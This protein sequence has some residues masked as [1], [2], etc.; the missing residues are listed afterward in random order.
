[1][2]NIRVCF[3]GNNKSCYC[4]MF[5]NILCEGLKSGVRNYNQMHNHKLVQVNINF[6]LKT[7]TEYFVKVVKENRF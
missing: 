7:F 6:V 3:F 1:M 4:L 5:E 2:T